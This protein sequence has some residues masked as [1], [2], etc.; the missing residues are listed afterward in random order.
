MFE[1][2]E[3]VKIETEEKMQKAVN[4][5]VKEFATI[6]TGRANPHLLDRLMIDYYGTET[7]VNQ[8]ASIT[9]V[10]GTQLYIKP[11]DKNSLKDIEKAIHASDLGLPP[12]N[13]GT[14]IRL[15]IP[16]LTEDRRKELTKEVDKLAEQAKVQI[17]NIRR[18]ANDQVK[19]LSLPE[20]DE[21]G[22][23]AEIQELTDKYTEKVDNEAEEK[24]NEIMKI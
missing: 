18:D 12:A 4:A 17:R 23:L 3:L 1:Q 2:Y 11:Y 16:A 21:H 14:G 9:V 15:S 7:P 8:L 6:R 24:N 10:E 19:K 22:S 13:D 20:D 5:L